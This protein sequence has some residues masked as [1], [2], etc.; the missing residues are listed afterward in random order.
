M[1]L[2]CDYK[3]LGEADRGP[4][5]GGMGAYAPASISDGLRAR[6]LADIVEPT[7]CGLAQE[8]RPFTGVLYPGLMI[9]PSGPK[10]LEFNCRFGDPEAEALLPLL[11]SDLLDVLLACVDG[12]L[13]EHEVRWSG[14]S[15]CAVVLASAGYPDRPRPAK[16]LG[17]QNLEGAVAFRGGDSGRILTIS[18]VG[19]SLAQ[20][21][22]QA[23]S[24][25]RQIDLPDGQHRTDIGAFDRALNL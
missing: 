2:S 19:D 5:T 16:P 17:W 8:G 22:A 7:M 18:A 15:C 4:N 9:G 3:R 25:V 24:P 10:V 14:D 21:R 23:Y 11:H 6:I 13:A 12:R 20:A 1:P